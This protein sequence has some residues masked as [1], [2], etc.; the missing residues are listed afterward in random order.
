[1]ATPSDPSERVAA[2]GPIT[3]SQPDPRFQGPAYDYIQSS[4]ELP[5]YPDIAG[6]DDPLCRVKL[7]L[8]GSRF[9]YYVCALTD[10]D[11]TLVVSGVVASPLDPRF[12]GFE[13]ANLE[14]IAGVRS[15]GLA[16][17]VERDLDFQPMNARAIEAQLADGAIP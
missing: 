14:E 9:T 17:P 11:G 15:P 16:L 6:T 2:S 7:F 3:F 4:D 13:D 8:T 12:D 5:A 1:V 10:H